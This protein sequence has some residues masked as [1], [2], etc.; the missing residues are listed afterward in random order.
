MPL[1]THPPA[2]CH[3]ELGLVSKTV[4]VIKLEEGKGTTLMKNLFPRYAYR[5]LKPLDFNI[6]YSVQ[7]Q[8]H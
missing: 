2:C 7:F 6:D 5:S 4:R 8:L 1:D 3:F